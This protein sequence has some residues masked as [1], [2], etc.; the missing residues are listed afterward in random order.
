[1]SERK[2]EFSHAV[3]NRNNSYNP[4]IEATSKRLTAVNSQ[5]EKDIGRHEQPLNDF[6][7]A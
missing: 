2:I 7:L 6:Y 4:S 3:Y 1:M 5:M